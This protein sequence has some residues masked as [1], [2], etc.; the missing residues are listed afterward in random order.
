MSPEI[1][2]SRPGALPATILG[3]TATVEELD[4]L[5]A[6]FD[7][8][9]PQGERRWGIWESLHGI[10]LNAGQPPSDWDWRFMDRVECFGHSGHLHVR[11]D[12]GL[13]RWLLLFDG[14][15]SGWPEQF[16]PA[17]GDFHSHPDASQKFEC[18]AGTML[19][20]GLRD[21]EEDT[22]HEDRVASA[23]LNYPVA[24]TER[25]VAHHL[26]YYHSGQ[27]QFVRLTALAAYAA[28]ESPIARASQG[29]PDAS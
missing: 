23:Q 4:D 24:A 11:L 29:G 17:D 27:L 20:W 19:L 28:T 6:T 10:T 18:V 7:Q 9:W 3:G 2:G 25:V 8:L 26:S 14:D 15:A 12:A 5:L 13:A 1:E 22:W 21:E 16:N